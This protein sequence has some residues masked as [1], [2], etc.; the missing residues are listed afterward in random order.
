MA[1]L[2][3]YS[4]DGSKL[5]SLLIIPSGCVE[6]NLIRMTPSVIATYYL[7]ST[8]QWEKIG[9]ERRAEAIGLVMK[10]KTNISRLSLL[11]CGFRS[12]L[13]MQL[14]TVPVDG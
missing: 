5:S 12:Q 2:T 8:G 4:I 1:Q 9:T 11:A 3:E 13:V 14:K 7:D 6:Q 10:G